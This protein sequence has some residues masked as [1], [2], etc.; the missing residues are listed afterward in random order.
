MIGRSMSKIKV[1]VAAGVSFPAAV[2][3]ALGMSIRDFADRHGILESAVS[4]LINGS[5][6]YPYQKERAALAKELD[7]DREWLDAQIDARREKIPA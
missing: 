1:L 6:P 4:G 2:K 3:A 7:V 5:T